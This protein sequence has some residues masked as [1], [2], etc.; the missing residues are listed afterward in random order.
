LGDYGREIATTPETFEK[1]NTCNPNVAMSRYQTFIADLALACIGNPASKGI[2]PQVKKISLKHLVPT[3]CAK[4]PLPVRWNEKA[5]AAYQA[6]RVE[7]EQM[8]NSAGQP[9]KSASR[10]KLAGKTMNGYAG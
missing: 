2:K 10:R 9:L 8:L 5:T 6:F 1:R 3:F 4:Y 7:Y